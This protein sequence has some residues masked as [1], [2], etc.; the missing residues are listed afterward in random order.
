MM[1]KRFDIRKLLTWIVS[2]VIAVI[3][4]NYIINIENPTRT[5]EYR[6]IMVQL[7]GANDLYNNYNLSVIDGG[8]ATVNVRVAASTSR[9]ANLTASQI[10]IKADLSE[11]ISTA[12][13]YDIP[14][15]VI[16]PES[17]MTCVGSS[18]ST[19]EVT[20]DRVEKKTVPVT[21]RI[22]GESP[23]GYKLGTPALAAETVSITGPEKELARVARAEITLDAEKLTKSIE[24]TSYD[25]KLI[26]KNNTTVSSGNISRDVTGVKLS[27]DVLRV[28]RVPLTVSLTPEENAKELDAEVSLSADTVEIQGD[29]ESVDSISSLEVGSINVNTAENGDTFKFDLE[30]PKGV[31]LTDGQEKSVRA[32]LSIDETQKQRFIVRTIEL[33]DTAESNPKTAQLKTQSLTIT[34]SGSKKNLEAIREKDITA[35]AEINSSELTTG[36]HRVG[37]TISAPDKI[38]VHGSY[39]VQI[40]ISE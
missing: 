19:I 16:L 29:P 7:T 8:D 1:R 21:I 22:D 35:V 25:Y 14:Y 38:T 9:L 33:H 10:K 20:V 15:E 4:W 32:V 2:A 17:G 31:E 37:V 5:L 23:E 36:K 11:S 3:L 24:D 26:S 30:L 34:I 6:D 40:E 13:T 12:G 28:K 18:P 39:S 27:L